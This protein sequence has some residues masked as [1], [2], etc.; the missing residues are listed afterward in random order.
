MTERNTQ[1]NNYKIILQGSLEALCCLLTE[2][3]WVSIA[4][5]YYHYVKFFKKQNK[6][7]F[8]A[9][10]VIHVY[11]YIYIALYVYLYFC[12]SVHIHPHRKKKPITINKAG[13]K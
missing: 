9:A 11:I 12:T 2:K 10:K 13:K 6:Y 7:V 1:N 3:C 5:R 8:C 4:Q